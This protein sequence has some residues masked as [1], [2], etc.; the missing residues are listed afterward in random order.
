M[1][2]CCLLSFLLYIRLSCYQI[3]FH[4][5]GTD[6]KT[7]EKNAKQIINQPSRKRPREEL[8]KEEKKKKR[9]ENAD[10]KR[11]I[12]NT[13]DEGN[14]EIMEALKAVEENEAEK[15]EVGEEEVEEGEAEDDEIGKVE[16]DNL[17]EEDSGS[18][19]SSS[20]VH[21]PC[22]SLSLTSTPRQAG[23]V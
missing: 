1:I 2:V 3:Q 12:G 7:L 18:N 11:K 9:L 17:D 23:N 20:P 21:S 4:D 15:D 5:T 10:I 8:V 16:N 13:K 22:S 14:I 19:Y 6:R